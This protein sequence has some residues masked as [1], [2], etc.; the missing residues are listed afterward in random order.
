MGCYGGYAYNYPSASGYAGSYGSSHVTG[1]SSGAVMPSGYDDSHMMMSHRWA[2]Q[3]QY[4]PLSMAGSRRSPYHRSQTMV[5][6]AEDPME[7]IKEYKWWLAGGAVVFLLLIVAAYYYY[8][9][10]R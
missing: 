6:A 3:D 8:A 2:P 4:N 1:Y 10:M 9:R 7:Y 5:V